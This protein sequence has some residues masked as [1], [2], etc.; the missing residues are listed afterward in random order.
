VDETSLE[1]DPVTLEVDL[2]GR[3]FPRT[4]NSPRWATPN[5]VRELKTQPAEQT[6]PQRLSTAIEQRLKWREVQST[7]NPSRDALVAAYIESLKQLDGFRADVQRVIEEACRANLEFRQD[8]GETHVAARDAVLND[9]LK[10]M[11]AEAS[12]DWLPFKNIAGAA[13]LSQPMEIYRQKFDASLSEEVAKFSKQLFESLARLV[14][15]ELCGLVE[16]LPNNCCRY[17]FFRRVVIQ[18]ATQHTQ[19]SSVVMRRDFDESDD[20]DFGTEGVIGHFRTTRS[21]HVK[22]EIRF[23]RHEHEVIDAIHASIGNS[24]VVMPPQIVRLTKSIPEWLYPF[25]DVI[26]GQI[27]RERIIERDVSVEDWS[28]VVVRDVPIIGGDP[29]IV[30]GPFVLSGWGPREI[31]QEQERRQL[32]Q[33]TAQ[34]K[35][36]ERLAPVLVAAAIF[37]S[38]T[39]L[40]LLTRWLQGHGG[41]LFV[42][43]ATG[44]AVAAL[45]QA[46]F[47]I[48]VS[49]RY[50]AAAFYAHCMMVSGAMALFLAE[51]T[52]ARIFFPLSWLTPVLLGGAA[53]LSY[54]IGRQFR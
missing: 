51:W 26:D 31:Q 12:S 27:V 44:T 24:A 8:A 5:R 52:V 3:R 14:D 54:Q 33:D 41:L 42:V 2:A 1:T 21:Q 17:H 48:A 34:Q 13:L 19:E 18:G 23:A 29:S 47:D 30:I 35:F 43:L 39:S 4:L 36:R 22:H 50:A 32:I 28:K 7:E 10:E 6:L 45:W 38:I 37:L 40:W 46:L 20:D 11:I 9:K 15:R 16:W 53:F 49:R 25:V